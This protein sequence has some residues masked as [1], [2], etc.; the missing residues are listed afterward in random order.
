MA[1]DTDLRRGREGFQ[2]GEQVSEWP[3]WETHGDGVSVKLEGRIVAMA[4]SESFCGVGSLA[5]EGR[6][7]TL[8]LG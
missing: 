3:G 2:F 1:L 8:R 7:V 5:H 4:Q 6:N